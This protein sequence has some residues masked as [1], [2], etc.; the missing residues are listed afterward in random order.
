[1]QNGGGNAELYAACGSGQVAEVAVLLGLGAD[2][3]WRNEVGRGRRAWGRSPSLARRYGTL[4]TDATLPP[5][6]VL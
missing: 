6:P 3:N 2:A 4:S 5:P 1:M